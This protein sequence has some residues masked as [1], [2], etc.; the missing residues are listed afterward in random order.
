MAKI[1]EPAKGARVECSGCHAIIEYLPEE[2]ERRDG[3]DIGGGPDG[4]ERVKCPRSG[5][6]GHGYISRW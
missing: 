1:V 6:P 4:W 3:R 5:C 2:V